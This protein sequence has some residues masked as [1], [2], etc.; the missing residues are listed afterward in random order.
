[1]VE[2]RWLGWPGVGGDG[3]VGCVY[4]RRALIVALA[5][6]K[7]TVLSIVG[8]GGRRYVD[9]SWRRWRQ[10]SRMPLG[11]KSCHPSRG[12]NRGNRVVG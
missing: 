2:K 11:R 5:G 3:T 8:C 9:I 1:M 12:G 4:A 7:G 6:F 10:R